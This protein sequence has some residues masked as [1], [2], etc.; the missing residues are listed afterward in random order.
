MNNEKIKKVDSNPDMWTVSDVA[1]YLK[2]STK[3]VYVLARLGKIPCTI[4]GA[5]FR[6]SR[7]KIESL[8]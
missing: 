1:K 6:F 4:L 7:K 3:T 8:V 2:L 5:N